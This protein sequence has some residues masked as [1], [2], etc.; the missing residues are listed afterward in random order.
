MKR[1]P[2][3]NIKTQE[4][5]EKMIKSHIETLNKEINENFLKY[6][7]ISNWWLRPY[8]RQEIQ[9]KSQKK[10]FL[11]MILLNLQEPHTKLE[12]TLKC[13]N[14]VVTGYTRKL[15]DSFYKLPSKDFIRC[16]V[17]QK[18]PSCWAGLFNRSRS[19]S[20]TTTNNNL[21]KTTTD[22]SPLLPSLPG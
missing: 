4:S 19:V 5:L 7:N 10:H 16:K 18:S 1:Q 12:I 21:V 2:L 20:V 15:Y 11:N 6:N 3:N 9:L 14:S 22:F 13:Y 17:P 8:Y